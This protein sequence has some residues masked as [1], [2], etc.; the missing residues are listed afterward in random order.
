MMEIVF[1]IAVFFGSDPVGV[2]L[3]DEFVSRDK[4]MEVASLISVV[5]GLDHP[6]KATC[7][8]KKKQVHA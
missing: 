8:G 6:A 4:C 2:L 7:V 1:L 3:P 5:A